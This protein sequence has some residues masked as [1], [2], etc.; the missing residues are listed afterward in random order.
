MQHPDT[1]VFS[2]HSNGC[3]LRLCPRCCQ[4]LQR[5]IFDRVKDL[6]TPCVAN[7]WQM[8]TLTLLHSDTPLSDQLDR[9][10]SSFRKLRQRKLW[11]HAVRYGYAVIEITY[12]EETRHWHPHLH[13]LARVNWID[14]SHLRDDWYAVTGDSNIIDCQQVRTGRNAALYV[15]KYV[16]KMPPDVVSADNGLLEDWYTALQGSR[17]LIRFGKH[18]PRQEPLP[19]SDNADLIRVERLSV[20]LNKASAGDPFSMRCIDA[21][22]EQRNALR[23]YFRRFNSSPDIPSDADPDPPPF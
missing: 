16:G 14:W 18:P 21:L 5:R 19:L 8:I 17:M 23:S 15:A 11:K 9:L 20:M 7:E 3:N 13:V 6:L 4:R 22:A 1:G 12:N 10:R 2:I